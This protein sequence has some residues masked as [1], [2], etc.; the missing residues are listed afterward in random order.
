MLGRIAA[1]S[2][3]LFVFAACT[4]RAGSV[5][6]IVVFDAGSSGTRAHVFVPGEGPGGLVDRTPDCDHGRPLAEV[7]GEAILALW[8]CVADNVPAEQLA[9]T[10]VRVF[11][12]A[13]MRSLAE[14]DPKAAAAKHQQAIDVLR[15]KG[16]HDVESRTIDGIDEARFAWLA[17]N[18]GEHTLGGDATLGILELGGASTQIAFVPEDPANAS[19]TLKVAGREYSLFAV[20]YLHCGANEARRSMAGEACFF[21][22]CE[23][24]EV[25]R[26]NALE[27]T[28]ASKG[29]GDFAGCGEGLHAAM[30]DPAASCPA[31]KHSRP[32]MKGPFVL[33]SVFAFVIEAFAAAEASGKVDL[34][35]LWRGAAGVCATPW[36][37]LAGPLAAQEPKYR[38]NGCFNAAWTRELLGVYGLGQ[39]EELRVLPRSPEWALGA[40]YL[41]REGRR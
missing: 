13:G 2:C 1:L 7:G 37:E 16:M 9:S 15:I 39:S 11:A 29:A 20:S 10:P 21:V 25:C 26:A 14:R 23:A 19:E 3:S 24:D 36:S 40:A 12:T 4:P 8:S 32:P 18:L 33:V 38:A 28:P 30:S 5:S 41:L 35:A 27:G 17:A 6:P 22:G 31:A 34:D